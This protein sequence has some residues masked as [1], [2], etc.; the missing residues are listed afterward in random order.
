MKWIS[1]FSLVSAV[2]GISSLK[3]IEEEISRI[4]SKFRN[5][6]PTLEILN[7]YDS[8][9]SLLKNDE[10]S[11]AE[12][13]SKYASL[14]Y[15]HGIINMA[16]NRGKLALE[17]FENCYLIK[18][19]N[20]LVVHNGCLAKL[21][22]LSIEYGTADKMVKIIGDLEHQQ[23]SK[24]YVSEVFKSVKDKSIE[25]SKDF[26]QI[27]SLMENKQWDQCNRKCKRLMELGGA[28]DSNLMRLHIECIQNSNIQTDDK[29]KGISDIYTTLVS[30]ETLN[31]DLNDYVK[32]GY[33][34]FF[35]LSN[36]RLE[37]DKIIRQCLKN[38]NEF[39]GC[40]DLNRISMKL[41]K[42]MKSIRE[43]G[44]YYSYV[45]SDTEESIDSNQ[46]K[47]IELSKE[48]WQ[49]IF[50]LLFE[51]KEKIRAKNELDRIAFANNG[52]SLD[53]PRFENN[54]QVVL[55]LYVNVMK[56]K[57]QFTERQ[58]KESK[59]IKDMFKLSKQAYF[60]N[61]K[62]K[63]YTRNKQNPTT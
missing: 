34:S 56:R 6:G 37:T 27:E 54:F 32:L 47:E 19:D 8:V 7:E 40:K 48:R 63:E 49:E 60:E 44:I 51:K 53:G 55:D 22:E 4:D 18:G 46:F 12:V 35:G 50:S 29:I 62:F 1:I 13:L 24:L 36:M 45:Y 9:I 43:V 41:E 58:L 21:G 3:S 17:D 38:D 57:F 10:W 39:Q 30:T 16:L 61:E 2:T 52:V 11:D 26:H 33:I 25:Y 42:L 31:T 14:L 5:V 15:K 59:F 28:H 23:T 20:Q